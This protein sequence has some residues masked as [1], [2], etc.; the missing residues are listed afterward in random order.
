M[1]EFPL[2]SYVRNHSVELKEFLEYK[3]FKK[4]LL[5]RF[6]LHLSQFSSEEMFEEDKMFEPIG[7][8]R[9][10]VTEISER[11]RKKVKKELEE[12]E[13]VVVVRVEEDKNEYHFVKKDPDEI[14]WDIC[15][16]KKE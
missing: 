4:D 14:Y 12:K 9:F 7:N 3:S 5:N 16:P 15:F 11:T 2:V 13:W 6:N 1:D 10:C 8:M